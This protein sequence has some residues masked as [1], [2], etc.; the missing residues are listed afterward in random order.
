MFL[1]KLAL[2][3]AVVLAASVAAKRFGHGVAGTLSGLPMIA[4]PII[5]FV[6]WQAPL[7]QAHAIAVATLV[8][9]PAMVS[10]MVAFAHAVRRGPWW[11]A[12]LLAN[13]VFLAVG[14]LLVWIALPL[15]AACVLAALAPW[16]GLRL[17]P[18]HRRE[19]TVLHIPSIELVLRVAAAAALAAAIMGGASVFP[20]AVS[21]LMLALPI[22]GN[23]LPCF[24]RARHG[25][26]AT[27]E[28]LAGFVRGMVGFGAFFMVLALALPA[29][30]AGLSY[31]VAWGLV[32]VIAW[33][34]QRRRS[35]L[36]VPPVAPD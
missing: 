31:V 7:S 20:A 27:I 32:L 33:M 24:T 15:P 16:A 35:A 10:H 30:G 2:V 14:G 22:T 1:L 13:A 21:G 11:V 19:R 28:L 36:T 18:A 29:L 5:G 23:V 6:L 25:A 17:M 34:L 8:A 12:L 26:D 4:G 3:C 9:Y